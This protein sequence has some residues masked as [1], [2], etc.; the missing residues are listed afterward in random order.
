MSKTVFKTIINN[1]KSKCDE[2]RNKATQQLQNYVINE[3]Q[4]KPM[5]FIKTSIEDINH[6]I[7]KLFRTNSETSAKKRWPPSNDN[8][9][10]FGCW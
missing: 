6:Q 10:S 8:S 9:N 2:E 3:V 7:V 4:G 1:L 5:E